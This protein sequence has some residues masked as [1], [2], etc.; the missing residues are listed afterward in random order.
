MGEGKFQICFSSDTLVNSGS[1]VEF[2]I[3]MNASALQTVL[4][5]AERC[6]CMCTRLFQVLSRLY[7]VT[8]SRIQVR[9]W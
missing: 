6:V 1:E 2:V 5:G 8:Q 7:V 3:G 9:S 4:K